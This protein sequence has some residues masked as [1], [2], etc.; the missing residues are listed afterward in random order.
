ML[1]TF[2]AGFLI[3]VVVLYVMA[4]SSFFKNKT[5]FFL[6]PL[7]SAVLALIEPFNDELKLETWNGNMKYLHYI[8]QKSSK[9]ITRY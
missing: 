2:T 8:S 5:F 9:F 1:I 6:R 4:C 7:I 3:G